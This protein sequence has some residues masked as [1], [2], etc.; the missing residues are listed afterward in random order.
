MRK[1]IIA[2]SLVI[3]TAAP[4]FAGSVA[5]SANVDRNGSV[6]ASGAGNLGGLGGKLGANGAGGALGGK[7]DR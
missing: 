7:I 3:M 2:L 4:S 1:F 6:S 5:T